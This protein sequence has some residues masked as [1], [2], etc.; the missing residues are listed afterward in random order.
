MGL[1]PIPS[2]ANSVPSTVE[3]RIGASA[4]RQTAGPGR[5]QGLK[6]MGHRAFLMEAE[7]KDSARIRNNVLSGPTVLERVN[8]TNSAIG[9]L[10]DTGQVI[11]LFA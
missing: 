9:A 11:D 5:A 10:G 7:A 3:V 6:D 1:T 8:V 4:H 2:S